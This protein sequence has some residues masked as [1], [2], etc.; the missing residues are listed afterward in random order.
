MHYLQVSAA[1]A[2]EAVEA[3]HCE[4]ASSSSGDGN[5]GGGGGAYVSINNKGRLR[6]MD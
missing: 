1:G 4:A 2:E 6:S 3:L 5:D